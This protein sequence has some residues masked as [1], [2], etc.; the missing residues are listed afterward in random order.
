MHKNSDGF[1][2]IFRSLLDWEWIDSPSMLTVFIHCLLMANWR[3]GR[4]HGQTIERGSF[5]TSYDHLAKQTGLSR[6]T[7]YRCIQKLEKTGEIETQVK[8]SY[9][10]IKVRN[11]ALFQQSDETGWNENETQVKRKRNASETQAKPIEEVKKE[12]TKEVIKKNTKRKRV[13]VIPEYWNPNPIRNEN[14]TPATQEEI[15]EI[16]KKLKGESKED[17]TD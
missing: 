13:E 5:V 16:K 3:D 12:R 6:S 7:V 1:I 8:Q 15:E 2:K 10:I 9:T 17:E 4:Y 11:Y 14:Q